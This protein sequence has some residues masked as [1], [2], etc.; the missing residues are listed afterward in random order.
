MDADGTNVLAEDKLRELL[1]VRTLS[2]M[3]DVKEA[4]IRKWVLDRTIP[5][6]KLGKLVR[7]KLSEIREWYG[8]EKMDVVRP[9]IL[10]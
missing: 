8:K 1:S 9:S 4:T 2:E 5:Y 6:H 3:L 10:R 7:F